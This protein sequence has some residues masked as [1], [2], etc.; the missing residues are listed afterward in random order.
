MAEREE[1]TTQLIEPLYSQ[2]DISAPIEIGRHVV[3]AKNGDETSRAEIDVVQHFIPDERL[4]FEF[5]EDG[6]RSH[7]TKLSSFFSREKNEIFLADGKVRVKAIQ[8]QIGRFVPTHSVVTATAPSSDIRRCVFHLLNFPDFFSPTSY[9]LRSGNRTVHC[10]RVTLQAEGWS[11]TICAT[12]NTHEMTRALKERGGWIL[13]HV[14]EIVRDDGGTFTSEQAEDVLTCVHQCLSFALGRWT[15]MGL[16]V[17]F[18]G[19]GKRVFEQWGLP[20][21]SGGSWHGS[22]AWF[23]AHHGDMLAR[24]F[25]GFWRLCHHKLWSKVIRESVYWYLGA[26]DRGVGIGVDSGL[27]LAQTA[28]ELLAWNYCVRDRAMVSE[29]A[30]KPKGLSAADKFRLLASALGLPLSIPSGL[31]ALQGKPGAKW[32]DSMDVI[33]TIR[34]SL[35]H[36]HSDRQ[37]PKGSEYEAWKLSLWYLDLIVL[38]LCDYEGTY[39]NRLTNHRFVGAVEPVP[40]TKTPV[41]AT[42]TQP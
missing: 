31:S 26:C 7:S 19:A 25:P 35:V 37:L 29:N 11:I 3:E 14:G 27:I 17:G 30:F 24:F 13:T 41:P 32:T 39:A 33:T 1:R 20:L 4:I 2:A 16:P 40:W 5:P 15:A 9:A 22:T 34:N 38:R 8:T 6:S 12:A 28:L 18:D 36:P 42:L 23:D 21:A 10:G